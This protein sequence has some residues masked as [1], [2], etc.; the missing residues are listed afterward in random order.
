MDQ[1]SEI[2]KITARYE[3]LSVGFEFIKMYGFQSGTFE[4]VMQAYKETGKYPDP[5]SF[6][7][8]LPA[9]KEQAPKEPI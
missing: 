9:Q 3:E 6:K 2:N 8:E 1:S 7:V 5:Q 4:K